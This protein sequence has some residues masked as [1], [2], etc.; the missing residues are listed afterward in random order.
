MQPNIEITPD[1]R[2]LQRRQVETPN[3]KREKVRDIT[4]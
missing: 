2:L 4:D 3:G 1:G